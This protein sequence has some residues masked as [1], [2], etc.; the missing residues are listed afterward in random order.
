[1]ENAK[2]VQANCRGNI[3]NGTP[4]WDKKEKK[5]INIDR[6]PVDIIPNIEIKQKTKHREHSDNNS[7]MVE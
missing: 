6:Y 1:M 4:I 3:K 5:L 7:P 2:K